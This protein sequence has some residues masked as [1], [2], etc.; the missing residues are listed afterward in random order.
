MAFRATWER[1]TRTIAKKGTE[2]GSEIKKMYLL[3]RKFGHDV[4]SENIKISHS[5]SFDKKEGRRMGQLLKSAWRE[6]EGRVEER[7]C[8]HFSRTA[9]FEKTLLG[10]RACALKKVLR[11]LLISANVSHPCTTIHDLEE[12]LWSSSFSI[13]CSPVSTQGGEHLR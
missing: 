2:K 3:R 8:G 10:R 12:V 6:T 9:S 5:E 7:I 11:L 4:K 1:D 13:F